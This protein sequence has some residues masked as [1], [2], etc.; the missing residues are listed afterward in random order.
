MIL[1]GAPGA[2]KG[3]QAAEI[4][5]EF[6]IPHISS[7]DL[8]RE[9]ASK[10]D[11]LSVLVRSY[12]DR[13]ALVPDDIT[14]RMVLERVLAPDCKD[15]FLLDGFPR[16]LEQAKALDAVLEQHGMTIDKVVYINVDPGELE[17]RLAGRWTCRKCQAVYHE[18]SSPPRY[19][20]ICDRCGGSL[21]QRDDDRPETVKRRLEVYSGQTSPLIDYY[22]KAGKVVEVDGGQT[23]ENVGRDILARLKGGT[24]AGRQSS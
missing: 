19:P 3:T 7:G 9:V 8:F 23:I 6:G 22:R 10:G 20:G 16:T 21:Y 17:K 1:L 14:V 24:S 11:D 5:K 12:M 13:G 2:G 15:G 18:V 4:S